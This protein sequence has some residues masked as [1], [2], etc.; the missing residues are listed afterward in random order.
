[1]MSFDAARRY[2]FRTVSQTM[3]NYRGSALSA[4]WAGSVAGGDRLPWTGDNFAPLTA[5]DWQVHVYGEASRPLIDACRALGI[6]LHVFP[7][8]TRVQRMGLARNAM[9]LLRPDGY[10]GLA[11]GAADPARLQGYMRSWANAAPG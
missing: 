1:V 8:E 7:W 3:I 4:G 11:D 10:V 2:L 6:S 9:Y 5:L